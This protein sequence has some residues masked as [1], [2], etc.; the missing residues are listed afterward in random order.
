MGHSS[1]PN[2]TKAYGEHTPY[3]HDTRRSI[4]GPSGHLANLRPFE[5]HS[6]Y[7]QLRPDG[8][9]WVYSYN[10]CIAVYDPADNTLYLNTYNYTPKTR[11]HQNLAAAWTNHWHNG[12]VVECHD[13]DA[14]FRAIR[15]LSP[16]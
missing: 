16:V 14:L 12:P 2:N 5:G 15:E 13:E 1:W 10:V 4:G 7:A 9:Y 8:Q 6:T 3:G 11:E